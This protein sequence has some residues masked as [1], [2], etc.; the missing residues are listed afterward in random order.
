MDAWD[1]D[2]LKGLSSNHTVIVF[3][4]RGIGNSTAG[5]K[6]YSMEL[7][8]NDTAGLLDALNIR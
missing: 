5:S 1:A 8:A 6:P 4:S 3:D 2:F 7:L